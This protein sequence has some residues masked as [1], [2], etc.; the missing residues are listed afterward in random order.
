[1]LIR[2]AYHVPDFQISGGPN[3]LESERYDIDAKSST[4]ANA[5]ETR[6]M[7]QSLLADR[8][9]LKIR[10]DSK[11]T[12]AYARV[13]ANGK[14]S[15]LTPADKTGLRARA[16]PHESMPA[17]SRLREH[18]ACGRKALDAALRENAQ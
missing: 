8:F 4:A 16:I 14:T 18:G 9:H 12:P 10:R 17:H 7:L 3:W 13:L 1:L 5:D 2:A 15:K 11:E 6:L